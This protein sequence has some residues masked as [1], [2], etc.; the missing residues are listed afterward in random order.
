MGFDTE[1]A[2][3]CYWLATGALTPGSST[4]VAYA[5]ADARDETEE[6]QLNTLNLAFA[7]E[8]GTFHWNGRVY[9]YS[10]VHKLPCHP[11]PQ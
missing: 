2:C 3:G 1:P 8:S 5:P 9:R 6:G 7:P 11:P 4:Y 10:A